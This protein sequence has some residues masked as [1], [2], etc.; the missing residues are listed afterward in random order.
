MYLKILGR[1][2]YGKDKSNLLGKNI[3]SVLAE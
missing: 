3:K 2:K 1:E